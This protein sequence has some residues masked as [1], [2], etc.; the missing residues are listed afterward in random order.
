[1]AHAALDFANLEDCQQTWERVHYNTT[2]GRW[3]EESMANA[4]TLRVIEDYGDPGFCKYAKQFMLT[5][6]QEYALGVTMKDF[7]P[8]DFRCIGQEKLTGVHTDLQRQ[9]LLYAKNSPDWEGLE[10]WNDRLLSSDV[11]LFNGEYF[12]SE[13]DLVYAIVDQVLSDYEEAHDEPMSFSDFQSIFP[14]IETGAEM[15]Y[16]P[17][18]KVSGDS[19]FP[20]TISLKDGDYSLYYWWNNESLHRFVDKAP[21]IFIEYKN[22]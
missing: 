3:R 21:S 7:G 12:T 16:E 8:W 15:S 19:R 13:A 6:P 4:V 22:N 2:F 5:Q 9:W 1:M 14:Y 10:E 18:S 17:S 11:Y 20:K